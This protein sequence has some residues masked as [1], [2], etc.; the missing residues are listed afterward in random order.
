[1][2]HSFRS[3]KRHFDSI[4]LFIVT[5]C[6]DSK[7]Q[8]LKHS[9]K[10]TTLRFRNFSL[11]G[12]DASPVMLTAAWSPANPV[13]LPDITP[14]GSRF[15]ALGLVL[16]AFFARYAAAQT[17]D[18][19]A[20]N[21]NTPYRLTADASYTIVYGGNTGTGE[22][23]HGAGTLT[24]GTSNKSVQALLVAYNVSSPGTHDLSGTATLVSLNFSSVGT[25]STFDFDGGTLQA[26]RGK[27]GSVQNLPHV[28]VRNGGAIID[29]NGNKATLVQALSGSKKGFLIT[30]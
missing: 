26:S 19:N 8:P 9:P 14:L 10:V 22:I 25:D 30:N 12:G 21:G 13:P 6:L 11:M 20:S 27:T 24:V 15:A 2:R 7:Q 5:S 1:M 17:L 28:N 16:A 3:V 4:R 23:D 29:A 18:V